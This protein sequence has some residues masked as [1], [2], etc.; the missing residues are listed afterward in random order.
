M[1][2]AAARQAYLAAL[3]GETPAG[4]ST[5]TIT[6]HENQAVE[7]DVSMHAPGFLVLADTYYPGWKATLD[8][9]IRTSKLRDDLP[10]YA[11]G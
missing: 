4:T 9:Q 11:T 6:R 10:A 2:D 3:E 7:I 8:G 1:A 5:A